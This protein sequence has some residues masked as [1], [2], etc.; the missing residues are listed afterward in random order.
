MTFAMIT[1]ALIVGAFAERMRFS[2]ARRLH[3]CC[4]SRSSTSRSLTWSGTG[5]APTPSAMPPERS[6]RNRQDGRASE[7]RRGPRRCGHALQWGALDFAGGTVVHINAGI[8]GLVG[9]LMLG[10]RIG[11]GKRTDGSALADHDHDR[12]RPAL[13]GLVRVQRRLQPR[14][15]RHHGARHDQHLRGDRRG[16][17]VLAVHRMGRKGKPPCSACCRV[18][19]RASSR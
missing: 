5:P 6:R 13:G 11:Y 16:G 18:R 1:P 7:A 9:A 15:Q 3:R 19:S 10:K 12:R 8:A 4:G 2:A 17:A 14:G